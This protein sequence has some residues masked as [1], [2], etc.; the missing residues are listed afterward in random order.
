VVYE[1]HY[2]LSGPGGGYDA[3]VEDLGSWSNVDYEARF[4]VMAVRG[5][6]LALIE[7]VVGTAGTSVELDMF[8]VVESDE[9]GRLCYYGGWEPGDLRLAIDEY[10]RRGEELPEV[11]AASRAFSA[12]GL[13][14]NAHDW[15]AVAA[16][17]S[18]DL[19]FVDRSPAGFGP[20]A[21]DDAVRAWSSLAEL[22][23]GFLTLGTVEIR[24][25]DDGGLALVRRFGID[26]DG[27][28]VSIDHLMA[29]IVADGLIVALE[30]FQPEQLAEALG[31]FDEML[32]EHGS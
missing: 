13:P 7:T 22:V 31:H 1:V 27:G 14:M 11:T 18:P 2:P 25:E 16:C 5:D 20:I 24:G 19:V 32:A 9:E 26:V 30:S 8:I 4:T 15:E 23:P 12:I 28:E 21:L 29:Y 3:F 17:Y 6:R 10:L